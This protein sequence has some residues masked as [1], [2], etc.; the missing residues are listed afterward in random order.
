MVL[1]GGLTAASVAA[2]ARSVAPY[3]VD[4]SSGVERAPGVKDHL[5]VARFLEALRG[6][7]SDG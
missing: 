4:V 6:V 5:L 2:A 3:A 7:N 1:A